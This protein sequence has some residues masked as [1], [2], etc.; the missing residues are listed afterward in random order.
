MTHKRTTK[1]TLRIRQIAALLVAV[2]VFALI[3]PAV[4][5]EGIQIIRPRPTGVG[6]VPV[7]VLDHFSEWNAPAQLRQFSINDKTFLSFTV[8]LDIDDETID[9]S[10]LYAL[11][12]E[13][14]TEPWFI[15][16][17]IY[18]DL[19]S[20]EGFRYGS[21]EVDLVGDENKVAAF[22]YDYWIDELPEIQPSGGPEYEVGDMLITMDDTEEKVFANDSRVIYITFT[23]KNITEEG[24]FTPIE[25]LQV[26]ASQGGE[27]L[28]LE[29]QIDMNQ[30]LSLH[31][32][33]SISTTYGFQLL[34][35]DEPVEIVLTE[36]ET[37]NTASFTLMPLG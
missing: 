31:A 12:E 16:D 20:L 6:S 8:H 10:D 27:P 7:E 1:M 36:T 3:S 35:S 22:E 24:A 30:I 23:I 11:I 9:S 17:R 13:A 19:V 21:F 5:A 37:D 28:A 15:Y 2:L 29:N 26:E 4:S 14:K 32:G 25:N 33:E 18:V 34:S